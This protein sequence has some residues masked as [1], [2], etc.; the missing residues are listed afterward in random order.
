MSRRLRRPQV[1]RTLTASER[2]YIATGHLAQ[3]RID[4]PMPFAIVDRGGWVVDEE[5]AEAAW[6]EHFDEVEATAEPG[7]AS[8]AA[9]RYGGDPR[10][11]DGPY[12]ALHLFPAGD[13][14]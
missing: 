13:T 10:P 6:R 11:Q 5:L 12:H 7:H 9:R 2:F 1:R 14:R 8:W 3:L 4:D